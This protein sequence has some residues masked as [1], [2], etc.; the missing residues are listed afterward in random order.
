MVTGMKDSS[1]EY[2]VIPPELAGHPVETIGNGA[3]Q[4]CHSLKRIILPDTVTAIENTAFKGCE[5]LTVADLG[6]G[7]NS[8]GAFSFQG[9][10]NLREITISNRLNRLE[11]NSFRGCRSV[12]TVNIRTLDGEGEGTR[13]F[14]VA[15]ENEGA[16]WLYIRAILRA[17]DPHVGLMDKYDATFLEIKNE[18]DRFR[19][20]AFRLQNHFQMTRR[21]HRI[22]RDC[23]AGMTET[24]IR[25]DRVDRL[26]LLGELNCIDEQQLPYFIDLAGRIGGG[27]IACLL[28]Y[29]NRRSPAR[30]Y[31]F[32]L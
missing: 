2:L 8:I 14:A 4:F 31:D 12:E 10:E 19:V 20:A 7:I 16:L 25:E 29:Q 3:F 13:T 21:M 11:M 9:C 28:E 15:S 26:T 18:D 24:I 22:Y 23:L 6:G 30:G 1:A 32:S 17:T 27:C 5:S